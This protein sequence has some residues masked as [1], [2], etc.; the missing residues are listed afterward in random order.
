LST[1]IAYL[2]P[3]I[4]PVTFWPVS[5][6]GLAFPV[7]FILNFL[8]F[9]YWLFR[10]K[11]YFLLSLGCMLLGLGHFSSNFGINGRSATSE[12]N[13]ISVINFNTRNLHHVYQEKDKE[14]KARQIK[15]FENWLSV[16][17][18]DV[19]LLQET[20]KLRLQQINKILNLP[21]FFQPNGKRV[22]ILSRYPVISSGIV[23]L[24]SVSH[25]A[26]WADLE[27]AKNKI[28]R[29]YSLHLKS[30]NLDRNAI[31]AVA[32]GKVREKKTWSGVWGLIK[33][34]KN[35]ASTRVGQSEIVLAHIR[36][37]PY[38][39][40]VGGDFNE[41]STSYVYQQ[42]HSQL[43]DAFRTAGSGF[44]STYAGKIP[45]LK[46]DYLFYDPRLRVLE[47]KIDRKPFSDHY[48]VKTRLAW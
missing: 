39:V 13:Q 38:P 26:I 25:L 30:S 36:K 42:F 22:A 28:I 47:H 32:A 37:S 17:K 23:E 2:S 27:V 31:D 16:N 40:V 34:Y 21:H 35:H 6:F 46:I 45:L 48:P 20:S 24:N 44:G 33:V 15:E 5:I 14:K 7:L 12:K 1:L 9:L 8:F 18:A 10:R 43:E 29:F 19:F 11:R 4:S 3:Y 41:P